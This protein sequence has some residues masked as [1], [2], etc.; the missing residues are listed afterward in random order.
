M[1]TFS[2]TAKGIS[3]YPSFYG[4]DFV[5]FTE[6]KETGQAEV[7]SE[8]RPDVQYYRVVLTVA[9]NGLTP[10]IKCIGNKK[11]ALDYA[12][13]IEVSG[14]NNLIVIVDKDL[15]GVT[16]SPMPLR[17]VI[18]TLGYSWENELWSPRVI[19]EV[20]GL[21]S[22]SNTIVA[23]LISKSLPILQKRLKYLSL[24]N[25][26]SCLYGTALLSN[27]NSLAGIR[28]MLPS[29]PVE[30]VKRISSQF[31]SSAASGCSLCRNLIRE[32]SN[33]DSRAVIRGHLWENVAFRLISH[34]YTQATGDRFPP[35]GVLQRLAFSVLSRDVNSSVGTDLLEYYR[36]ELIRL[37]VVK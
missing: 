13:Q 9:S 28:F 22:N 17:F 14:A 27:N 25:A 3:N 35:N 31:K 19:S 4:C 2:R 32:S 6:G 37:M 24:L 12:E 10:K 21:I 30:E 7:I 34:A 23:G 16:C 26:V 8:E 36:E 33:A 11:A 1:T 5:V 15:E 29:L 18:R 20:A